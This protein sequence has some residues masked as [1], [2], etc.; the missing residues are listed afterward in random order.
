M[1]KGLRYLLYLLWLPVWWLQKLMPRRRNLWILGGWYGLKYS[2][3]SKCLFEYLSRNRA[4]V[5]AVWMTWSEELHSR[6]SSEGLNV[7]K[8]S[9]LKGVWLHLRAKYVIYSSGKND[10]NPWFINGAIVVNTWHGA[11]MK[12]I[13]QD[14]IYG[15]DRT[16]DRVIRLLFPWIREYGIT[17]TVSTSDV[18]TPLMQSAFQLPPERVLCTGYPRNDLFFRSDSHPLVKKW[19]DLFSIPRKIFYLP[20]FRDHSGNFRPF[21][22]YG[23]DESKMHA[24]LE[25]TGS[26]LISKGHYIDK[27]LEAPSGSSRIIHL[28]D[29]DVDDLNFVLKDADILI[30][31][32]SGV[33]F[34]FLI[35][36]KPVLF[37]P[38]DIADYLAGHRE[39]YFDYN[40]IACGPVAG[41]WDEVING[42]AELISD[43]RYAAKR[44]EMNARFNKYS[45]NLNSDRL[46][47]ALLSLADGTT[48]I[49][50]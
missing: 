32:Y 46:F 24:F 16:K 48:K 35:T 15:Y 31:D 30:T 5:D 7:V 38:F 11:P 3:N 44:H 19:N 18:F 26:L 41:N 45:D 25:S 40:S 33:Y 49:V 47:L 8:A 23:F 37:S 6:L 10:V 12:K 13:G 20:T 17:A 21:A 2:D 42:L 34:D 43:D 36:G 22:N 28:N 27:Q 4:S 50:S 1:P 39:L 29:S 14:D 9:S